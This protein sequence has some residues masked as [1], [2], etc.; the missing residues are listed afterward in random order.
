MKMLILVLMLIKPDDDTDAD[1][2]TPLI[3]PAD[4]DGPSWGA[5]ATAVPVGP[6]SELQNVNS[7]MRSKTFKPNF[8]ARK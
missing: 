5:V 3:I 4:E 8:T 2:L 7:F 1:A 6:P